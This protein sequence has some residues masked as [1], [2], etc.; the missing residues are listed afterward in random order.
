MI[1]KI[2]QK[3]R[4]QA[5][6]SIS[7]ALLL[8]LVC[9]VLCSVII[10]AATASS[11]RMAGIAESDQRYYA[12]TSAAELLKELIEG[13][14]VSIV[15]VEERTDT[16]TYSNGTIDPEGGV[17]VTEV[18]KTYIV[19]DKQAG[20]ILESDYKNTDGT[21]IS[22]C[23]LKIGSNPQAGFIND[24]ILKDAAKNYNSK[25]ST[26]KYLSL[27]GLKNDALTV[28]IQE[29]MDENGDITLT[30]YNTN[31]T[32]GDPSEERERYT[33]VLK[34]GV[35]KSETTDTK[36]ENLSSS[37]VS[38]TEYKVN[39]K[40]TETTITSLTWTLNE[41]KT[42]SDGTATNPEGTIING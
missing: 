34:F 32:K 36:K 11:G 12:V 41:I 29:I 7:F 37:T 39:E 28:T 27:T 35:D 30:I 6:A 23:L 33:L 38:D 24:T 9:A 20:Q 26:P 40:T 3:L 14:P 31:N 22:S 2:K 10:T 18:T 42:N 17:S 16:T 19:A 8:F 5:G 21:D 15:E 1:N 4:S 13:K 25:T